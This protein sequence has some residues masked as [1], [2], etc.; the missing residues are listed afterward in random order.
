MP[1]NFYKGYVPTRDKKAQMKYVAGNKLMS[2]NSVK[3]LPEYAGVLNENTVLVDFDKHEESEVMYQ[4][5]EKMGLNYRAIKT[6]RGY[7]FLF[8]NNGSIKQ[9]SDHRICACGCHVDIKVGCKNSI[10]ILKFNNEVRP[11]HYDF[12]DDELE[13][14]VEYDTIPKFLLPLNKKYETSLFGLKNGD[15]RNE[16][17]FSHIIQCQKIGMTKEEI[18]DMYKRIVNPYI[19]GD[20]LPE[21]ELNS[22]TR[23][24]AFNTRTW[25]DKGGFHHDQFGDTL[26]QSNHIVRING[27]LHVYHEGVY[28]EGSRAIESA[29]IDMQKDITAKQRTEVFKYLQLAVREEAE[30]NPR[31]IGFKNGVLNIETMQMSPFSPYAYIIN[32][33]PW[34][35]NSNA[36]SEICDKT[37]DKMA[38]GDKEIRAL[39]EECIGYC[40]YKRN[41]MSKAF[42]LTGEKSNGKSTFLEMVKTVLGGRNVSSLDLG[43]LNERF[44]TIEI[45]GKLANIGDD[46]SDEFMQPRSVAT[47]KKIVSGN[48]IKGERK[49]Q[50][51]IF[52]KPYV[53]ML[54]SANDIPRARDK[55]GAL[56]RRWII[57]PFNATFDPNDPNYDPYIITKLTNKESIE[58]LIRIGVEGLRRVLE[59]NGFTDSKKVKEALEEYN[60][61]NN[62][63][64]SFLEEVEVAEMKDKPTSEVYSRYQMYCKESG[65]SEITKNSFTRELKRKVNLDVLKKRINGKS[66]W[67]YV[68]LSNKNSKDSM[69]PN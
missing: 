69:F 60:L 54:F 65:F 7:H 53:K 35:Y 49:G 25:S 64:L 10:E 20:S 22:I 15:G 40:F 14:D 8:L 18:R 68:L 61:Q 38:C 56:L 48:E 24:E 12:A 26:V 13:K 19:L 67:C 59:R 45:N 55:T 34:D 6:T 41:E 29:M 17:L 4:L 33:I 3:D 52:F 50:D 11:I 32:Q 28:L 9:C 27:E 21:S 37:L 39:L 63:L 31:D 47:F 23:D 43:E 66:V 58:Y 2:L 62:P 5:L 36:Y 1:Y 46:I 42:I 44:S 51:P 30:P 57:I 16:T